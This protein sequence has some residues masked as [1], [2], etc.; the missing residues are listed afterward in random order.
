MYMVGWHFLFPPTRIQKTLAKMVSEHRKRLGGG[1]WGGVKKRAPRVAK[2]G[3]GGGRQGP[4][5]SR[6]GLPSEGAM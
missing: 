1:G 5:A 2:N 6:G 3:G 4:Q